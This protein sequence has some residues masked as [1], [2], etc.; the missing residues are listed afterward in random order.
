MSRDVTDATKNEEK[1]KV[2]FDLKLTAFDAKA[3]IKVIKEVRSIT[4]VGLEEAKEMVDG[5]TTTIMKDLKKENAEELKEKLE[6]VGATV[7]IA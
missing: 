3:K 1:A 2:I 6:K 4:G 7:V 5:A